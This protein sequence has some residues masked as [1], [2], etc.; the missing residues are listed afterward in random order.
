[1]TQCFAPQLQ[2]SSLVSKP[3]VVEFSLGQASSDAGWLLLAQVDKQLGLSRR[4]ARCLHD[5]RHP[6]KIHHEMRELIVQRMLQIGG[7]Y[8]DG[9]DADRLRRDPVLK[10][11]C[12]RRPSEQ[13]LASQPT[14]SRWENAVSL[15]EVRG[16]REEFVKLFISQQQRPPRQV[17]LTLDSTA[18]EVHGQQQLRFFHGYYG[19]Y[20]YLPLI[21]TAQAD[22]QQIWPL[23]AWLRPAGQGERFQA[24]TLLLSVIRKL[25]A[26]WPQTRLIVRADTG[27]SGPDLYRLCEEEGVE[28]VIAIARNPRLEQELAEHLVAARE[29][30]VGGEES[31][32][33]WG[34]FRYQADSW[35]RPRQVVG[36]VEV[37]ARGEN[38]RFVVHSLRGMSPR[39]VYKSY[40]Q[41]GEVENR[42]KELKLALQLD[43]TSCHRFAANAFRVMLHVAAYVLYVALRQKLA[44]TELARAQVPTLRERLV[45]LA[46][47]VEESVRRVVLRCP[48]AYPWPELWF[49]LQARLA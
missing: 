28:Y 6:A 48:Q 19:A 13:H 39:Q 8:E 42:I 27:F 5:G 9:N 34:E 41:R 14:F 18:D 26:A 2:F 36:K 7:G 30:Y 44:G 4:L 29:L 25:K 3:V 49:W 17:I 37:T 12:G 24:T 16:L 45:K 47:L 33:V 22:G 23:F 21:C 35:R 31:A 15:R 40:C 46:G 10:L 38:Q 11:C 20:C 32:Q 1:M 43:R